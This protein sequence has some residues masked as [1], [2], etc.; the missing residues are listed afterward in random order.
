MRR[1]RRGRGAFSRRRSSATQ[2]MSTRSLPGQSCQAEVTCA[3]HRTLPKKVLIAVVF[4]GATLAV[5]MGTPDDITDFAYG[6]ALTEGVI[7]HLDDI[8]ELEVVAQGQGSE[9]RFWLRDDRAKALSERRRMMAGPVGCGLCGIDS[10]AQVMRPLPR[11][12]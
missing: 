6:F 2:A 3:V 7:S 12:A 11:V 5:M 9:A 10:L 1:R 4:N 8:E